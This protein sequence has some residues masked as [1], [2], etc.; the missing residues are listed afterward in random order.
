MTPK[1]FT[2]KNNHALIIE[3]FTKP[4]KKSDIIIVEDMHNVVGEVVV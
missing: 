2:N 1:I 4:S 3:D